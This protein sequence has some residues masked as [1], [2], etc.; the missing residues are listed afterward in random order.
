MGMGYVGLTTA[1]CFAS[2][3]FEVTG[4]E[5][6]GDKLAKLSRG[7]STIHEKDVPELLSK[8]IAARKV[9]FVKTIGEAGHP[10]YIFISVGTPS[11]ADGSVDL[12]FVAQAAEAVGSYLKNDEGYTV[13]V[14]RSTVVPGT[15]A[16]LIK[17]T[18]EAKSGKK[19]GAFGL[20]YNPEFLREGSAVA[21]TLHPDKVVV[22]GADRRSSA[23]L[24]SL[25]R[26]FY[27][28]HVPPLVETT[29]SNAEMIKHASNFFLSMKVSYINQIA[30]LCEATP[31]C[32]VQVVADAIG[33][34]TRI[35]RRFLNAGLGFGGSCFSKDL[36][37]LR[38]AAKESRVD[39]PLVDATLQ[40]NEKLAAS[41]VRTVESV[42]GTLKGKKVAVLGLAF[43]PDT[44]DM[45][46]AVSLRLIPALR[47]R[48]ASVAAYDPAAGSN[49]RRL[50]PR[51]KL[52]K[53]AAECVKGADCAVIVTEWEEF[54]DLD[55]AFFKERMKVP[56]VFD[57]RRIYDPGAFGRGGVELMGVGLSSR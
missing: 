1:A 10:D 42:M 41:A 57:G 33:Y 37:A 3:G 13:V 48:G 9:K 4:V 28:G 17:P 39:I 19:L 15:T 46:D 50:L 21:D 7:V 12:S 55:P 35:G 51:V 22:G 47:E 38:S 36:K 34:D 49:A 11:R 40:V 25:Y 29:P 18:L 23:A 56:F 43:K 31:G 14:P 52:A 5:V 27:R 2:R 24:A 44:D 30:A 26:M 32:D 20:A 45:R 8:G 54:K 16:S 53:S 6:D